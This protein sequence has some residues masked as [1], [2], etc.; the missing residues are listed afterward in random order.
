[1]LKQYEKIKTLAESRQFSDLNYANQIIASLC[2][3]LEEKNKLLNNLEHQ[4]KTRP[5]TY[6]HYCYVVMSKY[7]YD[8][9]YLFRQKY[10]A[11]M[12]RLLTKEPM[13]YQVRTIEL[14]ETH[15]KAIF[16]KE[17][18]FLKVNI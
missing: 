12:F 15:K 4:I 2:Q 13:D 8:D 10:E 5:V 17:T 16:R 1:M 18:R 6:P 9:V 14:F 11:E 3:E 7:K